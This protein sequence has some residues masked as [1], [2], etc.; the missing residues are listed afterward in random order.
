MCRAAAASAK[1]IRAAAAAAAV[2][3]MVL[4]GVQVPGWPRLTLLLKLFLLGLVPYTCLE[5]IAL[6]VPFILQLAHIVIK[7]FF[8]CHNRSVQQM[9]QLAQ[10]PPFRQATK[11]LL[12]GWVE[13]VGQSN[14]NVLLQH[15]SVSDRSCDMTLLFVLF[16]VTTSVLLLWSCYLFSLTDL[17]Q[18]LR[19]KEEMAISMPQAAAAAAYDDDDEGDPG[20]ASIMIGS[21]WVTAAQLAA[22]HDSAFVDTLLSVHPS[23]PVVTLVAH[24]VVLGCICCGSAMISQ[25]A[26]LQLLPRL[27]SAATLDL[28]CPKMVG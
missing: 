3:E 9:V 24:I 19:Q 11:Q 5:V 25:L 8:V 4:L 28:Y 1:L 27:G 13:F 14:W 18:W 12:D 26:V 22:A 7:L 20:R 15:P 6:Q 2:D 16:S 23:G 21:V 10:Q 17:L